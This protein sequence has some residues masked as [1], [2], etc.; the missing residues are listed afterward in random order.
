MH[1]WNTSFLLGWPSFRC[2]LLVSGSV[3]H[4]VFINRIYHEIISIC[5]CCRMSAFASGSFWR[6]PFGACKKTLDP[7]VLTF[8]MR[9]RET[10]INHLGSHIHHNTYQF[11]QIPANMTVLWRQHTLLSPVADPFSCPLGT[12]DKI[13]SPGWRKIGLDPHRPPPWPPSQTRKTKIT[14]GVSQSSLD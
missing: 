1:G 6:M 4:P 11:S 10:N 7:C 14:S 8:H 3:V 2:E 12:A 13:W 5:I 9:H